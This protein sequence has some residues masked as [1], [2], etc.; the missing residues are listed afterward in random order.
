MRRS[1][2]F[3]LI[4]SL[5]TASAVAA[6]DRPPSA[7]R[8]L[9]GYA[10]A[11]SAHDVER[12]ASYFTEDAIY[13]DVTLGE[14]H[15]GRPAIKAFAQGTFDLLPEFAIEQR[16]LLGG[17]RWAA[18]EWVMTGTDRATGKRFSVR[19]VSV[20]ELEG[21]KIR[22]NSD[23]WNMADLLR[24]TGAL[25]Q[26]QGSGSKNEAIQR[27]IAS[28]L[29]FPCSPCCPS[30]ALAVKRFLDLMSDPTRRRQLQ[31]PAS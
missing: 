14:V 15:R 29:S 4:V 5:T 8:S 19:G 3:A 27:V 20:M 6:Q 9:A 21:G 18:V 25:P 23:Y 13:E 2:H 22:R 28:L 7:A 12:I 30:V 17:E 1:L 16:S 11:W 10:E 24:Q 31:S 26:D